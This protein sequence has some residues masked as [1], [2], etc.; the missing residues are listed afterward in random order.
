MTGICGRLGDLGS[1]DARY[2]VAISSACAQLDWIVV[3]KMTD[4]E[5][6]VAFLRETDLGVAYF[7]PLDQQN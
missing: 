5:K 2:D 1:I 7:I 3:E 4:A 6:A